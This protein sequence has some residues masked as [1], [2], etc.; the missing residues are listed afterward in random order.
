MVYNGKLK[1]RT[2]K[3]PEKAPKSEKKTKSK[4]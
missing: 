4:K 1:S 3:E 2:D